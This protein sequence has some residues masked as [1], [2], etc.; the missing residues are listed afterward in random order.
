MKIRKQNGQGF[1]VIELLV[2]IIVLCILCMFVALAYS[3]VQ[4]KNR[5]V[6]RHK[7]IDA[8]KS[9]LE[10][11]YA[12]SNI[13]PTLSDVN[14]P[15]W[16]AQNLK[17]ITGSTVEDPNWKDTTAACIN[18]GKAVL[19]NAPSAKCYSYQVTG[20]DG[21]TCNNSTNICAH[22]TLTATLEGGGTYVK[23]SL[24]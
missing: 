13:Y 16:R 20:S 11:Y 1:T 7:D 21:N 17:K 8:L 4:A 14:N 23:S 10:A 24:N 2:V 15:T 19:A 3:G 9:Q 18:S 6:E 22:Y 12:E 5:N